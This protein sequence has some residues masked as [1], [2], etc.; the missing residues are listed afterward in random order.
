[1]EFDS[2]ESQLIVRS[3]HGCVRK[4]GVRERGRDELGGG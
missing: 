4:E 1:M 2:Q 3:S